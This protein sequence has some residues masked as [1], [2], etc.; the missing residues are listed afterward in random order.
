MSFFVLTAEILAIVL[1]HAIRL[2][3][4]GNTGKELGSRVISRQPDFHLKQTY[5]AS[6][7]K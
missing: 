3:H 4:E 7:L 5:T 6:Y 2:N 1:L